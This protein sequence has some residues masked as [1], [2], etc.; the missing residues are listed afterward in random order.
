MNAQEIGSELD[1]VENLIA[2]QNLYL[3]KYREEFQIAKANYENNFS[4]Y[5]LET[6]A[7]NP[8]YTAQEV[9][10]MAINLSYTDKLEEIKKESIYRRVANEVKALYTQHDGLKEQSFNLRCEI[11]KFS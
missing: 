4:R 11:K 8:D 2:E 3:S 1:R 10:A 5:L 6:K 7:K 9:K